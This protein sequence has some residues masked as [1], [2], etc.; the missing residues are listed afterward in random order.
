MIGILEKFYSN[1]RNC[2]VA[3]LF[4]ISSDDLRK[5]IDAITSPYEV[6]SSDTWSTYLEIS[7]NF[8]PLSNASLE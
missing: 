3:C 7:I 5:L 6:S 2:N 1:L 4:E 8:F